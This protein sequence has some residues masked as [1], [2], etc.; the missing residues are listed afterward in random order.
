MPEHTICWVITDAFARF[1]FGDG[2]GPNFT[3]RV[4]AAIEAA[5]PYRCA[6]SAVARKRQCAHRAC[7]GTRD[8]F[9]IWSAR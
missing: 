6:R 3:D 4:V 8:W 5:G 7:A 1:G 9:A 2:D